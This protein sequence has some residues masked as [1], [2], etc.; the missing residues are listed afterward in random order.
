MASRKIKVRFN[1]SRGK[2]FMKWKVEFPGRRPLYY[3]PNE[4]QFQFIRCTLKNHKKT[5]EKIYQG[6]N[7]TVCAWVLCDVLAFYSPKTVDTSNLEQIRYNPRIQPNWMWR[8]EIADGCQVNDV[9]SDGS[10]LFYLPE[11]S[12]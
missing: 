11:K 12:C 6:A 2:N 9:V 10:S 7:K 4:I 8:G 3:D 1:L 5:A